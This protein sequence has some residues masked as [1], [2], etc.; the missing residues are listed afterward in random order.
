MFSDFFRGKPALF[1]SRFAAAYDRFQRRLKQGFEK[2]KV[3][4]V[5]GT[6]KTFDWLCSKDIKIALTTGF[7][8]GIASTMLEQ[9]GWNDGVIESVVCSDEVVKG[10]PAPDLIF[11]AMQKTGVTS[12]RQTVAVGDTVSDVLAAHH[13]GVAMSFGVLTGS[14]NKSQLVKYPHTALL[15]SVTELPEYLLN[16]QGVTS[17]G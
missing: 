12:V 3:S 5:P 9:L 7:D 8:R 17:N 15:N 4:P 10:R 16:L 14:H 13:A 6:Q 2:K 11:K 1:E